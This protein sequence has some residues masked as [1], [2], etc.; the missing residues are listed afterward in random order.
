MSYPLPMARIV[1]LIAMIVAASP[2]TPAGPC[3]TPAHRAFDF[4]IGEWQVERPDGTVV[5]RNRIESSHGGCSLHE[6]YVSGAYTGESLN[7]YDAA[8]GVWHQTWVDIGG[9]LLVIEGGLR[10]GNMVLESTLNRITWTPNADGTVR[11]HWEVRTAPDAE[12]TT[13]FE[14]LYRRVAP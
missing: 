2:A 1:L 12:W 9:T 3:D 4:W 13:A 6:E 14:G 11:Q 5:G 10:D 8:R 7:T